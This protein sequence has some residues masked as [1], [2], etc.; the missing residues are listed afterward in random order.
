MNTTLEVNNKISAVRRVISIQ[1]SAT[2]EAPSRIELVPSGQWLNSWKGNLEITIGDLNEMKT[3]FD[4]GK[5][6]PGGGSAG[7]PIDYAHEDWE[8]AAGWIKEVQ[9]EGGMLVATAIEWTKSAIEAIQEGEFK[10]ISPSFYPACMGM[11][12]DP[13]DPTITARNVLMGAGLTNIPFFKGLSGLK[14]SQSAN[15][16]TEKDDTIYISKEIKGDTK[17]MELATIRAK[18]PNEITADERAFLVE[19]R[20]QLTAAEEVAF[21][22]DNKQDDK[23]DASITAEVQEA[24]KLQAS[25]KAGTHKLVAVADQDALQASVTALSSKIDAYENEKIEKLVQTHIARGAIKADQLS[26]WI[27]A[28]KADATNKELLEN[29]PSNQILASEAVGDEGGDA[30]DQE[31]KIHEK[32]SAVLA[33][34]REAGKQLSYND[35]RA[36]AIK[37]L[38]IKETK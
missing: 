34:A 16:S 24:M 4:A 25:I 26:K 23:I 21:N 5:G 36:Q 28:V 32:A 12:C 22:L 3:N 8:K 9:V 27:T 7:A 2:G 31:N 6:L 19:N 38:N 37:E 14:A 17:T 11:W 20:S 33:S 35:A 1:A 15:G 18:S 10:F 13:E 29:L 30:S